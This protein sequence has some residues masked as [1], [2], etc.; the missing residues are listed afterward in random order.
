MPGVSLSLYQS[1]SCNTWHG[2]QNLI[3][4]Y[5]LPLCYTF[6]YI[7][8][9]LTQCL[10]IKQHIDL[11]LKGF[12]P[13]E[14][15]NKHEGSMFTNQT[16]LSVLGL[17]YGSMLWFALFI[18]GRWF[19]YSQDRVAPLTPGTV[20]RPQ[21]QGVLVCQR[22]QV[23]KVI[24]GFWQ[25]PGLSADI[26]LPIHLFSGNLL[27][28]PCAQHPVKYVTGYRVEHDTGRFQKSVKEAGSQAGRQRQRARHRPLQN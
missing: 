5:S 11:I 2:P 9:L 22:E 15:L 13:L 8:T 17:S 23:Y 27:S 18:N 26:H 7:F 3:P 19:F 21:S 24:L 4:K 6:A 16:G 1:H 12:L 20:P 28:S 25:R 14:K 10:H